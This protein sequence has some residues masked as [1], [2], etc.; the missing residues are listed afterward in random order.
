MFA[1]KM[2]VQGWANFSFG[3]PHLEKMLQPRAAHSHYKVGKFTLFV[4]KHIFI[5]NTFFISHSGTF[6]AIYTVIVRTETYTIFIKFY[7]SSKTL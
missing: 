3:G 2:L 1:I 5:L 6:K 4:N 7:S